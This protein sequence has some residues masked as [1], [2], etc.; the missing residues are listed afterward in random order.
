MVVLV[1]AIEEDTFYDIDGYEVSRTN[2]VQQMIDYYQAKLQA[3][4]TRVTDFNE[5]SEIRNLLESVAVDVYAL[6]EYLNEVTMIAFVETA[7]GEWLDKH[8]AN[9]FVQLARDPGDYAVGYVTFTIPS[10]QASDVTIPAGTV[11]ASTEN[12]LQYV[13]DSD[14]II[15]VGDTSVTG[16][17]TCLTVGAD[18]NCGAGTVTVLDDD[19]L[20]INGLTVTNS[21]ALSGGVDYEDDDFY[22]QRLLDFIRK[23]DFGSL[24]YYEKLC[25][26]VSGV[27]DV[28]F[29]SSTGYTRKVL[30]NGNT[31]PTPDTVLADVLEVLSI[32]DNIVLGH[33]FT[34]D[35]PGYDDVDLTV[36][37]TVSEEID[38]TEITNAVNAVFNGD[39]LIDGL[40]IDESLTKDML[41]GQLGLIDE[42]ESIQVLYDGSEISTITPSSN[43]V[44]VLDDLTINQSVT[45]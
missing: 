2:L 35:K 27:H 12:S 9:P 11:V 1:L 20:I 30:V 38:E 45:E 14:L 28:A 13:T 26:D 19:T 40:V 15:S 29:I 3:G 39:N 32:P 22:R 17:I 18:G 36:N 37:L 33:S 16:T 10:V 8:G 23:D 34:V 4:E 24:S 42:I 41:Y 44:L 6:M 21:E 43:S 25:T 7:T 5:G 31:K